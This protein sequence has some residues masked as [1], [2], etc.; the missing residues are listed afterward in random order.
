MSK[1]I[2]FVIAVH[3]MYWADIILLQLKSFYQLYKQAQTKIYLL[4]KLL[5]KSNIDEE[6]ANWFAIPCGAAFC[7]VILL[8]LTIIKHSKPIKKCLKRKHAGTP[9]TID[10]YSIYEGILFV[11]FN[12]T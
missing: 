2:L 11:K 5:T 3:K 1:N 12:W 9:N 10:K 7:G 6:T 4:K 8:T